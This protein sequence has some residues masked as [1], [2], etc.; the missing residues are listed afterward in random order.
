MATVPRP[1][2][3]VDSIMYAL[4]MTRQPYPSDLTDAQWAI[5]APLIPPAK[6]GGRP[7]SVDMREI[8]NAIF[9]IVRNGVP[10]RALP[11]DFPKQQ[12]VYYYFR[13]WLDEAIW[14][15]IN[16]S[17]RR[18]V[19]RRAGRAAEPTA[20]CIDSQSVKTTAIPGWRGYDAGKKVT[21]RKRSLVVD[22]MG[23]LM[24]VVVPAAD[25]SD[26][27]GGK[28]VLN[29]VHGMAR[30]I[31][32]LWGDQHYGGT[33]AT[34]AKETYAWEL[35]IIK[36]PADAAGFVVLPWRWVVERTFGWLG[37]Y[38]RLSKEYEQL[39]GVS[40]ACIYAA[41]IHLMLRRLAT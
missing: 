12:I 21:G 13:Y 25:I 7:R 4:T 28:W 33:L 41:M 15:A 35:E 22:T 20:G 2:V 3:A 10:W 1:L 17:L 9:Y 38:R 6:P 31:K 34:W 5:L 39:T 11:H 37:W 32:K 36:R 40:E 18:E 19:R 16:D 30:C 14:E 27:Q 29:L 23:L 8:M 26:L 24:R